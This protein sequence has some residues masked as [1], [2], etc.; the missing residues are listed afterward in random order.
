MDKER[1]NKPPLLEVD[2][3]AVTFY[4]PHGTFHVVRD[5]S[6]SI[7]R[8]EVLALVG[9]TGCGKSISAFAI[10]R[11]LLNFQ[12]GESLVEGNIRFEGRD[13]INMPASKLRQLRGNRIAM[14]YQNPGMALNPT[15]RIGLQ[16]E[17][18]LREHLGMDLR[19]ARQRTA[20]LFDSVGLAEPDILGKRYPH[21]LSGGM[22]QRVM[23]AMGLAC[24]PDLLIM[25]EPTTALD[26]T[27][28][29]TILDLM[30]DLKRRVNA[31]ILYV[32]HNLATVARVADRVAV[33]YAGQTIEQAATS[34]IFKNSKHPYAVGLLQCVPQ[35]PSESR[36]VTS[37]RS[38]PGDTYAPEEPNL[39]AC[40][41]AP[42]CPMAEELCY[43]EAPEM[44]DLGDNN[45][46][47]CFFW[48]DVHK[49]IWGELEPREKRLRETSE[50]ILEAKGL[51][52][53]FGQW[54]RKYILFGPRVQPPVRAVSNINFN[55][56]DGRTLS[57]VGE[58]G[59]GKTTIARLV[60]GLT[61]LQ[62]GEILLRGEELSPKIEDRTNQQRAA[63][64]MVFQN[65]TTSLN[66]KLPARHAITRSLQ[67]LAGLS[68]KESRELAEE[69]ARSVR[70][71]PAY[72]ERRPDALSGGEQQ[73]IVLAA[74]FAGEADIIIAD[75]AVAS[76]DVSV[77]AQVLK[78]L[79]DYQ[80]ERGMSYIF[81]SHDLGVVRYISDDILVL[82]AGHVAELGPTECVMSMPSHPYTEALLS[83]V[84]IPDPEVK[85]TGVRL[86]GAVPTLRERFQGCFFAGRCPRKIGSLC[87]ETPPKARIGPNS[88]YHV[89]Y[90]HLPL[91]EL[92]LFQQN[93]RS[94]M[95]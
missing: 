71:E 24:D 93:R 90:C 69:M 54:Q 53:F 26:V 3:L 46:S 13:L 70:L 48:K 65:P 52:R 6:F 63:L 78:L 74:A 55:V 67:K 72:L 86:S 12:P 29:A 77:Q 76:L 68:R 14:V 45:Q 25:D 61:P 50:T 51:R 83:A 75:E 31:G 58:S 21:Q 92:A 62:R 7:Q 49:E 64:R 32:S 39:Q 15:M 59:C 80:R 23:I 85:P 87:D 9:E 1:Q 17:E 81:I 73:R 8:G 82:Y 57:I 91:E 88:P 30:V 22:Q 36:I 2:H 28:E 60:A 35:P 34:V 47:R 33:M 41:F 4:T 89:I 20:E 66:P 84:P 42:R 44:L 11:Y 10:V 40:L 56:G 37:L 16:M 79:E 27:T 95:I 5:V 94:E 43:R 18:V 38:I 19:K